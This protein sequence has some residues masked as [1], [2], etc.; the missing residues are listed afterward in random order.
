[1]RD[2]KFEYGRHDC[3]LMASSIVLALTGIDPGADDRGTYDSATVPDDVED[4]IALRAEQHGLL[5]LGSAAN[6]RRGDLVLFDVPKMGVAVGVV[7]MTG[8]MAVLPR[9][10]GRGLARVSVLK[11]RRAWRV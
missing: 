2:M 1:M 9:L 5:E 8:R 10:G 6:A 11:A 3:A 4:L 7:D